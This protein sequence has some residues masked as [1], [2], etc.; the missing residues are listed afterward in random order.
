MGPLHGVA[1]D[2]EQGQGEQVNIAGIYWMCLVTNVPG[3]GGDKFG[4][5][6]HQARALLLAC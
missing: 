3:V 1:T 4:F 6:V 5:K 2:D